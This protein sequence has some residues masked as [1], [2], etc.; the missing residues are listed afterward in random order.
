VV[1]K[2]HVTSAAKFKHKL[3][4]LSKRNWGISIRYKLRIYIW[5]Q[6]KNGKTRVAALIKLG[7]TLWQARRNGNLSK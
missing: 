2:P 5:K 1:A 4:E 7:M 6:W 3:K